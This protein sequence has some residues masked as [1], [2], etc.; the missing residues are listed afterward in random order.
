MITV[1]HARTGD[2]PAI[3]RALFASARHHVALDE[4]SF[5]LP[6]AEGIA[7][8]YDSHVEVLGPGQA[9]FVGE[10]DGSV[11]GHLWARIQYP[12]SSSERQVMRELAEIRL[13]VDSLAVEEEH[14]RKGVGKAL[15]D[16]AEAWGRDLGA[17]VASLEVNEFNDL[18]VRFYLGPAGY[19]RRALSLRKSL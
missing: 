11:V 4:T 2:G 8:F 19:R 3:V 12:D 9:C 7:E 16:A 1:R 6:Q 18:A 13:H 10:C 17:S 15:M 5:R 14:R